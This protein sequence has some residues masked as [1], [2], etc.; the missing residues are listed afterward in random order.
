[1][2]PVIILKCLVPQ[3]QVPEAVA[4]WKRRHLRIHICHLESRDVQDNARV[5]A[6]VLLQGLSGGPAV[7][8]GGEGSAHQ[9]SSF[10]TSLLREPVTPQCFLLQHD[11]QV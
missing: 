9:Y 11:F 2:L 3:Q 5:A 1:M 6:V 10:G 7:G 8:E 4:W